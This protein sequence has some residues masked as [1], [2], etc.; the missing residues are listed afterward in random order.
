MCKRSE[1]TRHLLVVVLGLALL[2]AGCDSGKQDTPAVD[3]E[4][5]RENV[6]AMAREHADDTTDASAGAKIAPQRSVVSDRLAYAEVPCRRA[7]PGA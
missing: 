7:D 4:A 2:S 3:N 1:F 6:E 5:A